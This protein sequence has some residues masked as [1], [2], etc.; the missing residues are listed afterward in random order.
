VTFEFVPA[1]RNE[2][3]RAVVYYEVQRANL[4][5]EFEREVYATIQQI[6]AAP[7]RF[8]VIEGDIRRALLNR[9]PYAVIYTIV[10][11]RVRIIAIAHGRRR[12]AYWRW[13]R[14]L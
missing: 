12:A 13:R 8:P 1:A 3:L 6:S 7:M 5:D 11:D 9:F 4:G 14:G 2:F 10:G